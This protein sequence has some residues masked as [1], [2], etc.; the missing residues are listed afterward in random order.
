MI[1]SEIL[2]A[3]DNFKY[4]Q[5]ATYAY[6][7]GAAIAETGLRHASAYLKPVFHRLLEFSRSYEFGE[8]TK[9][10]W[11]WASEKSRDLYRSIKILPDKFVCEAMYF[12][13]N[14]TPSSAI[15]ET[16]FAV[17]SAA[18]HV[19]QQE[20]IDV[21]KAEKWGTACRLLAYEEHLEIINRYL[22]YVLENPKGLAKTSLRGRRQYREE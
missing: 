5:T 8:R 6:M 12:A 10:D 19:E 13:L 3:S 2:K 17:G 14:G 11:I 15:A 4:G 18:A 9:T 22:A 1:Y 21:L 20:W 7:I 16:S